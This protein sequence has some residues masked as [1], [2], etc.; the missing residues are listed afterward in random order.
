M[1]AEILGVRRMTPSSPFDG[2]AGLSAEMGLRIGK[3]SG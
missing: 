2:N 1:A 3:A